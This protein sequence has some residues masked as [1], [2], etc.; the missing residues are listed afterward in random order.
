MATGR[1]VQLVR[2]GN[3]YTLAMHLPPEPEGKEGQEAEEATPAEEAAA[4]GFAR[5]E[6]R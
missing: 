6:G 2:D 4:P 5:P 1:R 3:V